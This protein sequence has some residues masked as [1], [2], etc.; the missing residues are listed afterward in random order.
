MWRFLTIAAVLLVGNFATAQHLTVNPTGI[1]QVTNLI[2]NARWVWAV[3]QVQV[4][5]HIV[6]N[7]PA[8]YQ[9]EASA[10]LISW[11]RFCIFG[12]R[13]VPSPGVIPLMDGTR[14]VP[15]AT[16]ST[17]MLTETWTNGVRELSFE[18]RNSRFF[19]VVKL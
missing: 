5:L 12:Y 3:Q 14:Q 2:N 9:V 18:F 11:Q 8:L 13:T 1:T 6:T 17:P 16:L 15:V 7:V 4:T 19:R 10:D